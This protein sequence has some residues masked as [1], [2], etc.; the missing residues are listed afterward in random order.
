MARTTL[1]RRTTRLLRLAIAKE[2]G[3]LSW[4][5][6]NQI[7]DPQWRQVARLS[8]Y[9]PSYSRRG[10][11]RGTG[12]GL[13]GASALLSGCRTTG[14]DSS[15][16]AS[17]GSA[18]LGRIVIVGGGT[19]GLT[20]A[21]RLLQA[22]IKT[23]I[24]EGSDRLGGRMYT[25]EK[26]NSDGMFCERGGELVDSVHADLIALCE[27]LDLEIQDL[28]ENQ[29]LVK[30]IFLFGG[31]VRDEKEIIAAF[32]PLAQ[33]IVRDTEVLKLSDSVAV[34]T[35]RSRLSRNPNVI[36][37]DH[38][39]LAQYFASLEVDQWL[40]DLL[41]VTYLGMFGRDCD[42]QSALNFLTLFN[43]SSDE[44][45]QIYGESDESK[46]IKGGSERLP[47]ALT[48]AIKDATP[49]YTQHRLVAVRDKGSHF[50]LVFDQNG[51]TVEV[52]ADRVIM[53]LPF[54]TL[55]LVD[56]KGLALSPAK[57][58]AINEW[59]YGTSAK[60]MLGFKSRPW[61]TGLR[62]SSGSVY[63]DYASQCFWE[64]SG[65]QPGPSGIITTYP[66]GRR[67][68]VVSAGLQQEALAD[69]DAIFTGTRQ[70]FDGS[71]LLQHWASHPYTLG[72]HTCLLPGQYTTINGAAGEA[73]LSGRML[74][75]GEHCSSEYSGYMNGAVESGNKVA[76]TI[77]S[78]SQAATARG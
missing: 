75:A 62:K 20:A 63:T 36:R 19:A 50:N 68:L 66:S 35:Y 72:S 73:E 40:K 52:K 59:G 57:Q 41:S 11:L 27:E 55:R 21:Y 78:D 13:V 31:K 5:Q 1:A 42:Q 15:Q 6:I 9:S 8:S 76:K 23:C 24:Y 71:K 74:F 32:E 51:R 45:L 30:D 38:T 46:R 34:P 53:A 77:I 16:L 33:R 22:N 43:P 70:E 4:E 28:N 58:A 67:G 29:G 17:S 54:S 44:G 37:L 18:S 26:F 64:T 69:L 48:K 7:L 60:F 56:L 2:Q 10:F 12:Y 65:L 49:I 47:R 3:R 61:R 14:R 39:T 25:Q